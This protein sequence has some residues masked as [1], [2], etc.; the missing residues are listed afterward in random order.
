MKFCR[1]CAEYVGEHHKECP[2]CGHAF[3]EPAKAKYFCKRC[4]RE[5]L[6]KICPIHGADSTIVVERSDAPSNASARNNRASNSE[7]KTTVSQSIPPLMPGSEPLPKFTPKATNGGAQK[8]AAE[9]HPAPSS[10]TTSLRTNATGASSVR[11]QQEKSVT[12]LPA[13]PQRNKAAA[14]ISQPA[15]VNSRQEKPVTESVLPPANSNRNMV[16]A[17]PAR[18]QKTEPSVSLFDTTTTTRNGRETSPK[19][20][21]E[22]PRVQKTPKIAGASKGVPSWA[23]W[24]GS[25]LVLIFSA[26]IIYAFYYPNYNRKALYSRAE[27]L[28]NQGHT[29]AAVQLYREYKL[30]YPADGAIPEINERINRIQQNESEFT[31]KQVRIFEL[32]QKAAEAYNQQHYLVPDEDNAVRYIS[33][34]LRE[35]P[36]FIP[37]LEL[38]NRI[39]DFYFAQAEAAFDEDNYDRAVAYYQNLLVIKPNNTLIEN[40]LDRSLKLKYVYGMLDKSSDL[41]EAK[42]DYKNLLKEKYKL[43]TQIREERQRLKEVSQQLENKKNNTTGKSAASGKNPSSQVFLESEPMTA[44]MAFSHSNGPA[45]DNQWIESL[46][47][48]G[49]DQNSK[50]GKAVTETTKDVK[51]YPVE[52]KVMNEPPVEFKSKKLV[53]N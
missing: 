41:A 3:A 39:V 31:Q 11:A 28:L 32:M 52:T 20:K 7:R 34:I 44:G 36:D 8:P 22:K 45:I 37:A 17:K 5:L 24:G 29:E 9:Q 25:A 43:K 18:A 10:K 47:N 51:Q 40:A 4:K 33:E 14:N 23:Y 46:F 6:S 19:T 42:A 48:E 15:A 27:E 1:Q 26:M 2:N 13:A 49:A 12:D 30:R 53:T 50:E 38:Q 21:T 16:E 35:D